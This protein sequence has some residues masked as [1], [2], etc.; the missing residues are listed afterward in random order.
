MSLVEIHARIGNTV[1]YYII[2]LALWGLWRVIRKQNVDSN[3]WGALFIGEALII[4]Q[5]GL[6]VYLWIGGARPER[7]V[8][9]LYGI[10]AALV[11]P[12]IY[13]YTKGDQ[14]QRV[15]LIYGIALLTMVGIILRALMT[16]S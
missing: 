6:G 16:A 1:L 13:A 15:M 14:D 4:L 11:I 12:G 2:I 9:I 10:V 5:G 3:Y 8:H 7:G